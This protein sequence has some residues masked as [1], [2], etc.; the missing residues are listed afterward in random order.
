MC[1]F[2]SP[3]YDR[4]FSA[5]PRREELMETSLSVF[6]RHKVFRPNYSVKTL[7]VTAGPGSRLPEKLV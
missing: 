4:S 5:D 3:S 2:R 1:V 6:P 7:E